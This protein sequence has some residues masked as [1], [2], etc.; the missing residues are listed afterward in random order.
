MDAAAENSSAPQEATVAAKPDA[1][2]AFLAGLEAGMLGVLW[3]LAW[4]GVTAAWQRRSFWTTE[5]LMASA[6]HPSR[7]VSDGFT[8]GTISGL[9][10]YLFLYSLLGG[11]FAVAASRE[12]MRPVRATLLAFAFALAWYYVSF[13]WI[14]MTLAPALAFLHAQGST[15]VG[16]AIYGLLLGRFY[17]HIPSARKPVGNAAAAPETSSEPVTPNA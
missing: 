12:S 17:S 11:V 6:F 10:L 13:S 14:W 1:L 3:M 9:A 8:S 15:L 16:H 4:L 5:N 2:D 7:G